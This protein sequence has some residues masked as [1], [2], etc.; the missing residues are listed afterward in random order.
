MILAKVWWESKLFP[1]FRW[2]IPWVKIEKSKWSGYFKKSSQLQIWSLMSCYKTSALAGRLAELTNMS[3]VACGW[4]LEKFTEAM[5]PAIM[6]P[7]QYWK[8]DSMRRKSLKPK[9]KSQGTWFLLPRPS[10]GVVS[11]WEHLSDY[12][13]PL[14]PE[15]PFWSRHFLFKQLNPSSW[16]PVIT[17]NARGPLREY[18]YLPEAL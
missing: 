16:L 17:E 12:Q 7:V 4:T 14:N 15:L 1:Y 13:S 5:T 6:A 2:R 9:K 8:N 11:T 10:R 18:L 3:S